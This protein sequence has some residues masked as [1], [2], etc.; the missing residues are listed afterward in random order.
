MPPRHGKSQ[1]SCIHFPAWY[2][3]RNPD[4][5]VI[6]TS[7]TA[8]LAERHSR[9]TR[10]LVR[11]PK[12]EQIFSTRISGESQAVS[13]WEIEGH[14]GGLKAIGVGGQITGFGADLLI[15][16]DPH[17]DRQDADSQ[18]QRDLKWDWFTSAAYTRLSKDGVI[19]VISTRWHEDDLIGRILRQSAEEWVMLSLPAIAEDTDVLGRKPGEPLWPEFFPI[20]RLKVIQSQ[21]PREWNALYQQRPTPPEGGLIKR[22]WIKIVKHAPVLRR[23][24]RFWD[25]AATSKT[26][27]DYTAGAKVGVDEEGNLYIAD[28]VRFREE[29]PEARRRIL[30]YVE[31]DGPNTWVGI[32]KQ[33]MQT[34]A[35]Q[36]LRKAERSLRVPLLAVRPDADKYTRAAA[37]AARAEAGRLYVV[38]GHWVEAF[39]NECLV[40][41]YGEHDDQI[42]AVSGAVRVLWDK[43]YGRP[44]AFFDMEQV[45]NPS[46]WEY[47]AKLGGLE[48]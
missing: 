8:D 34:I 35:I 25:L 23:W 42:D 9:S 2:L 44:T 6:V 7:A 28:I 24:V 27:G 48:E 18:L 36:D 45:L 21:N 1:L 12:Y 39:I 4:H 3:G 22:D 20:E 11:S 15:I 17:K 43:K 10:A 16:D 29:W 5:N 32:E 41:P 14:R 37:W 31:M 19:C 13:Q 30:R 26:H 40:F 46:S 47:Y 33:G 38:D